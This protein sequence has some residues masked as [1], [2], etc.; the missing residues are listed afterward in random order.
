MNKKIKIQVLYP[1][2]ELCKK[3]HVKWEDSIGCENLLRK[4]SFL[5][6][7]S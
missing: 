6:E 2:L 3:L 4:I 5:L 1:N 7:N